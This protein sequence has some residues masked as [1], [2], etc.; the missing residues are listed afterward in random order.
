MAT[1]NA[2]GRAKYE[3]AREM[4]FGDITNAFTILGT[5]FDAQP[6]V[7]YVQNFTDTVMDFSISFSGL[8]TC[9]SLAAGGAFTTDVTTNGAG[10]V[11]TPSSGEAVFV[12]YRS[13]P[14]S[15]FVQMS[16]VVAA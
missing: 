9:F 16:C 15:G 2:A 12:K 6:R 1:P 3:T 11:F 10:S 7:V 14:A 13:A 8:T 5:A 4:A